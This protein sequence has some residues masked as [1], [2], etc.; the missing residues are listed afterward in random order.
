MDNNFLSVRLS[1]YISPLCR[2]PYVK[3]NISGDD[4]NLFDKINNLCLYKQF[5]YSDI[6][7]Q[8]LL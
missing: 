6:V 4:K 7:T 2:Q 8:D 3:L 1:Y 5:L